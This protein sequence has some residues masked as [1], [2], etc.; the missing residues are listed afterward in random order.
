MI[1]RMNIWFD[2]E[3]VMDAKWLDVLKASSW[4]LA[5]LSF[6]MCAFWFLMRQGIIP[7]WDSPIV[8]YGLPLAILVTGSLALFGLFEF[9]VGVLRELCKSMATR[10]ATRLLLEKEQQDLREYLPYLSEKEKMILGW[11]VEFKRKSF[12]A[13]IDGGYL[14]TLIHRKI[15]RSGLRSGQVFDALDAPFFIPDHLWPILEEEFREWSGSNPKK[16]PWR[17][18]Y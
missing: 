17:S 14:A 12:T 3:V 13:P 4:Q 7:P 5:G 15:V 2:L 6:A 16:Q 8:I 11:L 18:M 10:R 1:C 9:I